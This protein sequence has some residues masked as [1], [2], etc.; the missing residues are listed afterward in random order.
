[1]RSGG[2]ACLDDQPQAVIVDVLSIASLSH[3]GF[4]PNSRMF[5]V[6]E[7]KS[8]GFLLL[9]RQWVTSME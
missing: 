1:M 7:Q 4:L 6:S 3:D 5:R 2:A 9:S 8:F